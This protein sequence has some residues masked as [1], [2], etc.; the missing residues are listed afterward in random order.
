MTKIVRW[1]NGETIIE[2]DG[3][4]RE[5]VEACAKLG[6]KSL[7]Y[8]NLHSAILI[9]ANLSS[10]N[11]HSANLRSANLSS[12]NLSSANLRSANLHSA[13]LISANLYSAN[14]YSANLISANLSSANLPIYCNWAITYTLDGQIRIGCKSKTIAEWDD[15]FAGTDTFETARG[16]EEFDRIRANFEAVKRYLETIEEAKKARGG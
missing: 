11:L 12:A 6:N 10:A 2:G 13:N 1:D 16:T 9:S 15:W 7:A 8:A 14:L 5:L 3:T 4:I